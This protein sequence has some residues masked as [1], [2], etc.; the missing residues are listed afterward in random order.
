MERLTTDNPQGCLQTMLNYAY[1]KDGKVYL[2]YGYGEDDID[3]CEYISRVAKEKGCFRSAQEILD[4]ACI[5]CDCETAILY[6]IATQAAELRG[7]LAAY[8]DTGLSPEEVAPVRQAKWEICS[9]G[10]YP[11]CS[12]CNT[13]PKGGEMTDYCPSCGAK[14]KGDKNL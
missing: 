13:E 3:L 1:A 9:D 14:M 2:R 4:G 5:E 8:E 7:R 10:Y 6:C 12:A 11:Y